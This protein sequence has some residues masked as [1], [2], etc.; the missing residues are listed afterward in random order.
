MFEAEKRNPYE[1][2]QNR[3][4]LSI[5]QGALTNSKRPSC[6]VK[7]VYP[8]HLTKGSGAHVWDSNQRRYVCFI[9][10]LGADL[11]GYGHT[12]IGHAVQNAYN[13]GPTL[14]L[15]TETEVLAAEKVK[16]II[17][18]ASHVRFLKTGSEA[19]LAALRIA[20]AKTGRNKVLSDG[21]HGWADEFVSMTPPALGVFGVHAIEAFKDL[22]Q[23]DERT[24]AV[25]I[26]PVATDYSEARIAE[27]REIRERCTKV[28][29][30]LIFD[31]IITGFRFPKL[32]VAC[33]YNITPD[34]ICLGKALG[35]G[36]PLSVVAGSEEFMECGEWFISSTHAG[37]QCS[38]SAA[39]KFM[40]L[41]QTK[42]DV[43]EL[44]EHGAK[45]ISGFNS[46]WPEKITIQ[47]Y[48]ARGVF[49][50]DLTTKALL[51]QEACKAGILLGSSF[52][53]SFA[54]IGELDGVLSSLKDIISRIQIGAVKLEGELPTTP[55]SQRVRGNK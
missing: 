4:E 2:W 42:Y 7:G 18:F 13:R 30:A 17:P 39:T 44:W 24:A 15:N 19:C 36:L 52:F 5:A 53:L 6:F 1:T 45:F 32:T 47:G 22:S 29:A 49:V 37:E 21:Y 40:E 25:I 46:L 26:E 12:E 55:F 31:E 10:G 16:E 14:S 34:L 8:T 41:M 11:L 54:H 23:I 20:R 28:G 35:G 27:L 38:L 9:R 51:W 48:P 43:R 3:E 33:E 50:G